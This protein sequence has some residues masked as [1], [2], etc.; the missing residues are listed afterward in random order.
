MSLH[1]S[2]HPRTVR[3]RASIHP[4]EPD[5]RVLALHLWLLVEVWFLSAGVLSGR[6]LYADSN[7]PSSSFSWLLSGE[8]AE[9]KAVLPRH[10]KCCQLPVS[11]P[12]H[13]IPA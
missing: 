8:A 4:S 7:V 2:A 6:Q 9:E 11:P 5:W 3:C 10:P 12:A 1:P 13:A